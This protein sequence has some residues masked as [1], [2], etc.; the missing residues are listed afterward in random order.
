M[1]AVDDPKVNIIGMGMSPRD[2]T[3]VHLEMIAAAQVLV[4]GRRHLAAFSNSTARLVEIGSDL[5]AVAT[6]IQ[7]EMTTRRVVVLAS[8]DPLYFG[9][10]AYLIHKLGRRHVNIWPNVNTVAAAFARIGRPWHDAVVVSLHGRQDE[11][12]LR[13][14]LNRCASLAVFT[15]R[16]HSPV[17][18]ARLIAMH[19]RAEARLCVLERMGYDD[20]QV[21]WLTPAEAVAE[22]FHDPNLVVVETG[23]SDTND[24]PFLGLPESRLA[25]EGGMI[26]KSEVRAVSLSKLRLK[27][28]LVFWD[29]GAGSGAVSIEASCLTG[30]GPIYAVEKDAGRADQI[31]TNCR[32]WR[33]A[34]VHVIQAELPDGMDE[35]PDPDRVFIGGGGEALAATITGVARRLTAGG[36]IVVNAVLLKSMQTALQTMRAQGLDTD[37]TQIQI[38]RS[39]PM[40][41]GER[42]EA[43]NPVWIM[44]GRSIP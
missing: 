15:D 25:H 36:I 18:L 5:A 10:G 27:P 35:L 9:I 4:G 20:E 30:A 19:G 26:T 37:L 39:R 34:N 16:R 11:G 32:A 13:A 3:P 24:M 31:R 21:R 41:T 42:M 23:L 7:N 14:V 43:L 38:S 12:H 6:I 29:L 33:A 40:P 44:R 1:I 8:G 22:T 2:L 17:W 28:G